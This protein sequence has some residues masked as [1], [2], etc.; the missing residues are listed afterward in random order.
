MT[1]PATEMLYAWHLQ[2]NTNAFKAKVGKHSI[3]SHIKA[4]DSKISVIYHICKIKFTSEVPQKLN[5]VHH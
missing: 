5:D 2:S 4:R 3:Q 1:D